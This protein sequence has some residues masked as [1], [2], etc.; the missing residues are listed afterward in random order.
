MALDQVLTIGEPAGHPH[1]AERRASSSTS[2]DGLLL[3]RQNR[4]RPQRAT[5]VDATMILW[6]HVTRR[7]TMVTIDVVLEDKIVCNL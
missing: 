5:R 1:Q 3:L 6:S 7:I 2:T 4:G